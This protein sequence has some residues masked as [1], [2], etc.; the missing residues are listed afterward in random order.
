[1]LINRSLRVHA[2][3]S[4]EASCKVLVKLYVGCV[5]GYFS[6]NYMLVGITYTN[7]IT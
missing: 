1:M 2:K 6:P 7:Q 3:Y 4:L 5:V